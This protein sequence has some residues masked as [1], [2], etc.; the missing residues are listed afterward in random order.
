MTPK[1]QYSLPYSPWMTNSE[2][3]ANKK[4]QS[5]GQ[6]SSMLHFGWWGYLESQWRLK[7]FSDFAAP[8]PQTKNGGGGGSLTNSQM[9][10]TGW[11]DIRTKDF[12]VER[13]VAAS[14]F[15]KPFNK[16]LN[17][18]ERNETGVHS[19]QRN[20]HWGETP[21]RFPFTWG[22]PQTRVGPLKSRFPPKSEGNWAIEG[23][24]YFSS[25]NTVIVLSPLFY[26]S[27]FLCMTFN[28]SLFCTIP[29]LSFNLYLY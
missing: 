15:S 2:I 10:P 7:S 21:P 28:F 12:A 20:N 8:P 26:F 9:G 25:F 4:H 24:I 3:M 18:L 13:R 16:S 22:F 14:H 29:E 27:I 23:N 6:T 11:R 5:Q 1:T 17:L 19:P